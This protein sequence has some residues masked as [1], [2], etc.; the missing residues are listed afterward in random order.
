MLATFTLSLQ[1]FDVKVPCRIM[2]H[3]ISRQP[4]S[5]ISK[6][7]TSSNGLTHRHLTQIL[8]DSTYLLLF[9]FI[10]YRHGLI[11]HEI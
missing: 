4:P 3:A 8:A 10:D 9:R 1:S 11:D 2:H 7:P 5:P 6:G